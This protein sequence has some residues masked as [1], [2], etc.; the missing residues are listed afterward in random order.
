MDPQAAM[1]QDVLLH[2]NYCPY[3]IYLL[4]SAFCR[5]SSSP[6]R[7]VATSCLSWGRTRHTPTSKGW[8]RL[9]QPV[10][11][12]LR[13]TKSF[14]WRCVRP[15]PLNQLLHLMVCGRPGD[16][17]RFI[18]S[19]SCVS[20]FRRRSRCWLTDMASFRR[21]PARRRSR[22]EYKFQQLVLHESCSCYGRTGLVSK[23]DMHVKWRCM[24][25]TW[26]I[27]RRVRGASWVLGG[28]IIY[29]YNYK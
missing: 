11:R 5:M 21:K 13:R 12:L 1:I 20:L 29:Y 3:Y 8:M 27:G 7:S 17:Y 18:H 25:L 6:L 23:L 2:L 14:W 4:I 16:L 22:W 19:S 24:P 28:L 10:S 26:T 9:I 15:W